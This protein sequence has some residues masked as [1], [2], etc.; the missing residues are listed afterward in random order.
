LADYL[1]EPRQLTTKLL[2]G[3]CES[4]FLDDQV[5]PPALD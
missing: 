4:Y 1:G 2:N 5:A 3:A